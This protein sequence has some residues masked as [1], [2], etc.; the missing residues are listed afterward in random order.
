LQNSFAEAWAPSRRKYLGEPACVHDGASALLV[1]YRDLG[2]AVPFLIPPKGERLAMVGL[3]TQVLRPL[4]RRNWLAR[5]FAPTE[6][7]IKE[8]NISAGRA[9]QEANGWRFTEIL[10]HALW[11]DFRYLAGEQEIPIHR[12]VSELPVIRQESGPG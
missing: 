1:A 5:D 4:L 2:K 10:P 8:K 6:Q 3:K 9:R 12:I 11:H 7:S